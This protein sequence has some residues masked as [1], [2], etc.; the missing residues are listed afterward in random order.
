[1]NVTIIGI[2][3]CKLFPQYNLGRYIS[4]FP[5]LSFIQLLVPVEK[6]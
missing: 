2:N 4:R 6:W 5:N 1:M 3:T